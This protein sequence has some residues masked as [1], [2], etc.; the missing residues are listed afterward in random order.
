M[1]MTHQQYQRQM[2]VQRLC[3]TASLF[4]HC[5]IVVFALTAALLLA[6]PTYNFVVSVPAHL[7]A[8]LSAA[9]QR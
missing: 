9:A 2:R 3:A 8:A 5:A 1:P 7:H 4:E 6:V